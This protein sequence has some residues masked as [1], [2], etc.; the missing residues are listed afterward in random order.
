[1][2]FKPLTKGYRQDKNCMFCGEFVRPA[3][4]SF[5]LL[6]TCMPSSFSDPTMLI[7]EIICNDCLN[8]LRGNIKIEVS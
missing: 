2:K 4:N 8:E 3:M 6:I 1:M 5:G 7:K